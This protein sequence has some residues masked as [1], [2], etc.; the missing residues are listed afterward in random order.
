MS[1]TCSLANFTVM[2]ISLHLRRA[3][4]DSIHSLFLVLPPTTG[5]RDGEINYV[6]ALS[7]T[8]INFSLYFVHLSF[9]KVKASF[10]QVG[11]DP[12][13]PCIRTLL[14]CNVIRISIVTKSLNCDASGNFT[15]HS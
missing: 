1:F 2:S 15:Q 14:F 12:S 4:T 6:N 7:N 3:H 9:Q 10:N 11:S 5:T 8:L 13:M